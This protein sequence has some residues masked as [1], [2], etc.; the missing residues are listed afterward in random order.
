M[1]EDS[2][3]YSS[4]PVKAIII[5]IFKY[6]SVQSSCCLM[7]RKVKSFKQAESL[8][9]QCAVSKLLQAF[10]VQ[11]FGLHTGPQSF[12]HFVI[13]LSIR[14]CSKSVQKFAVRVSQVATVVM[15]TMQL[16]ISQFKFFYHSQLRTK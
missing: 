1:L 11:S 3:F 13:A 5:A 9:E 14:H 10:K 4:I 8:S 6:T 2:Y 12:C 7:N 15:E 16:V